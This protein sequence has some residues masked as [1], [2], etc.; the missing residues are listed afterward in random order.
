[1]PKDVTGDAVDSE[2]HAGVL[3][4]ALV[5]IQLGAHCADPGSVTCATIS[6]N[7]SGDH[8]GVVVE[9]ADEVAGRAIDRFI[10]EFRV[11]ERPFVTEHRTR[12]S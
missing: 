9:K 6:V 3:N 5:V 7:Q 12:S 8:L 10:V 4:P 2:Y 1:M 11:V